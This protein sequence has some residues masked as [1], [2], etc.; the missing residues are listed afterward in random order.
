MKRVNKEN[1]IRP[2]CGSHITECVSETEDDILEE[3]AINKAK[4]QTFLGIKLYGNDQIL[5]KPQLGRTVYVS[6]ECIEWLATL[7]KQEGNDI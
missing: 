5:G 3:L 7:H 1:S 6:A 2:Y 4:K